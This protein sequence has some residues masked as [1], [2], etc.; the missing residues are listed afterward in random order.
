MIQICSG[1]T[2]GRVLNGALRT[3]ITEVNADKL[4]YVIFV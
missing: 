3:K 2:S 1:I 4:T